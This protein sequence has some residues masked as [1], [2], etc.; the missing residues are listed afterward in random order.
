M[1]ETLTEKPVHCILTRDGNYDPKNERHRLQEQTIAEALSFIGIGEDTKFTIIEGLYRP[2][3]R[4]KT[5]TQAKKE[6]EER[7]IHF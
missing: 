3:N 2:E 4:E 5:L 1:N 7:A 6:L